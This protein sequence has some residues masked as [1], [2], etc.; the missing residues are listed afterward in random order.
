LGWKEEAAHSGRV[1]TVSWP[2]LNVAVRSGVFL[3][4]YREGHADLVVSPMTVW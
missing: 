2:Y 1:D 3:E 4:G